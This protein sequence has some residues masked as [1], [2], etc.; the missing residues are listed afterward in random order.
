VLFAEVVDDGDGGADP[1]APGLVGLRQRAEAL[2]GTLRVQSP[3]GGPTTV[4]LE[5]PCG[6]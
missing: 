5:L 6:S 4:T 1:S 2:D 3:A